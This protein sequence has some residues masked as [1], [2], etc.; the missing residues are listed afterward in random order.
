MS[1]E[2]TDKPVEEVKVE[3]TPKEV[4][5]CA[6]EGMESSR[7]QMMEVPCATLCAAG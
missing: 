2:G 6:I 7:V 4:R 3:E 5:Y 1:A